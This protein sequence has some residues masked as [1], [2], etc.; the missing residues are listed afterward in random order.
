[1]T[2][3]AVG[4]IC[5]SFDINDLKECVGQD[6]N[7]RTPTGQVL[8]P[9]PLTKLGNPRTSQAAANSLVR[10]N[11]P[12]R[13]SPWEVARSIRDPFYERIG[14][15]LPAIQDYR[16]FMIFMKPL[17]SKTSSCRSESVLRNS[18]QLITSIRLLRPFV[19]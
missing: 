16:F 18:S 12:V 8:S 5:G 3:T 11:L 10:N 7:L 14:P 15:P 9:A 1:M 13:A 6:L 19:N 17:E 2:E 4:I